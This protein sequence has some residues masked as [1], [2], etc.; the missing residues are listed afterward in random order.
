V[1]RSKPKS[2]PEGLLLAVDAGGSKTAAWLVDAARPEGQRVVGRGRAGAG[3]P[4]STGFAESTR[5]I[6]EA[7]ANAQ[8]DA[9]DRQGLAGHHRRHGRAESSQQNVPVPLITTKISR[10]ILSIAGAANG[11]LRDQFI[12]WAREKRLAERVA[13]VPDVLPV[14]AVGTPNCCGVAVV[15]GTGSVAFARAADGRTMLCGGWGYLLGDEG[16]GYAIGRAAL[17]NCMLALESLPA[18]K[19]LAEATRK[20]IGASSIMELTKTIYEDREPRSAIASVAPVV[21]A[22]AEA[23]DED[24]QEIL[25]RA[26]SDLAN[27]VARTVRAIEPL[28]TPFALAA[29]GGVLIG[30]QRVRDQLQNHLRRMGLACDLTVV[31]EPLDGC[32]R[33]ADPQCAG[34][35]VNWC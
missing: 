12:A 31:D 6:A 8:Q 28:E 27:L 34:D 25:D 26:A 14:L 18:K 3:N 10:A 35:L 21:I 17:Q 4:L 9:A 32:V 20:A 13:I 29:S 1:T 5:A 15:S 7:A 2:P 11:A 30:S 16:S 22:A 19:P 24:A 23:G 33:L